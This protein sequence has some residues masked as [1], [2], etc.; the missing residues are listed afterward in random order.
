[1]KFQ[2]LSVVGAIVCLLL[3]SSGP[4]GATTVERDG[5]TVTAIRD[6]QIGSVFYDVVF[7]NDSPEAI[8]GDPLVF[9]FGTKG[10]TQAAV[11]TVV[12]V[13][14][15]EGDALGVGETSDTSTPVFRVGFR[16]LLIPADVPFWVVLVL[17]GETP[18]SSPGVWSV[19]D[20]P[21]TNLVQ[22]P[23]P[24]AIFSIAG[25]EG[26]GNRPP[27]AE[28]GGPYTGEVG[29]AVTFDSVGSSDPDGSIVTYDWD[30]GDGNTGAG[31][32]QSHAYAV[33]GVYH[34]TLTV[35]DDYGV[36]DSDDTL[37]VIGLGD[38]PPVAIA[39][40]PYTGSVELFITFDGSASIDPDGTIVAYDWDFGD[41]LI[42]SGATPSHAYSADGVYNV[43]LTVTD[44]SG[45]TDSGDTVAVIG[46]GN[47]P[48]VANAN[49]PYAGE[50]GAVVTFD[51]TGSIDPEGST[52]TYE[53]D[54]GD[55]NSGSGPAPTHTYTVAGVYNVTLTVT[56]DS[57]AT[58]S[59]GTTASID[60]VLEDPAGAV[61]EKDGDTATA[62]RN[63]EIGG[64]FYDVVFRKDSPGAIYG[65]PLVFPF[66][67]KG[68][69]QA[70]VQTVVDALNN[71][72]DI[73]GVGET[74]DTSTTA[75]RVGYGD[76]LI[77][78]GIPL[79]VA[80]VVKGETPH[81]SPG[82][83]SVSD[84][85]DTNFVK[86]PAPFAIFSIAAGDGTGD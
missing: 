75:F 63:L 15:T 57:G 17:K 21:D 18:S 30:F 7:R 71:E 51:G 72:G 52:L 13:L 85:P 49:G 6:L 60:E 37:A 26:P 35:I 33:S 82:V 46:S 73:L 5:D 78:A 65:D 61:V 9:P 24:F 58:D 70:A 28:A 42:S 77:P 76:L 66:G 29:V 38:L 47:L 16:D 20:E 59:D 36:A 83:W 19:S 55:A 81:S 8:Y 40:G 39:G 25:S 3:V 50:V 1:M 11:Q 31:V 56:D 79:R 2:K 80:I 74:S 32:T 62:I 27:T 23:A 64:V 14:S 48:P 41:G 84:E 44:D 43:I 22:V 34:V 4:A 67:S 54:F 53:W 69:T 12:D 86:V 45:A 10:E 68:E